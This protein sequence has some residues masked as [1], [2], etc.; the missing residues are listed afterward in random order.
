MPWKYGDPIKGAPLDPNWMGGDFNALASYLR[1]Q[2]AGSPGDEGNSSRT[3]D[4]WGTAETWRPQLSALDPNAEYLTTAAEGSGPRGLKLANGNV[5]YFRADGTVVDSGHSFRDV[6]SGGSIF[7]AI[8]EL[9]PMIAAI[10]GPMFMS[11]G[12][13]ATLTEAL[14]SMGSKVAVNA[15]TQFIT[16]GEISPTGLAISAAGSALPGTV[17]EFPGA[18]D[19]VRAQTRPPHTANNMA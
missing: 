17:N 2:M 13:G 19:S 8:I 14:G 16:T 7:D 6:Q 10:A 18:L 1:D 3:G 5:G 9:S 12:L 4:I 15:V 11:T